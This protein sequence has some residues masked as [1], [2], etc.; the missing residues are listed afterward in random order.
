[1]SCWDLLLG[2][3]LQHVV[4]TEPP[5]AVKTYAYLLTQPLRTVAGHGRRGVIH[6]E[7]LR[8][9][10][11]Q[12]H[13]SG[14][15]YFVGTKKRQIVVPWMPEH[16]ELL[17]VDALRRVQEEAARFGEWLLQCMLDVLVHDRDYGDNVRPN[18]LVTKDVRGRLEL[19]RFY[20][21]AKV[22]FEFNGPQHYTITDYTPTRSQ[23]EEQQRLDRIKAELCQAEGIRLITVQTPELDFKILAEK[24]GDSLP[25]VPLREESPIYRYLTRTARAYLHNLRYPELVSGN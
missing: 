7:T 9:A 5:W 12:L 4:L 24:I 15:V 6:P 3:A 10:V 17:V 16:V 20:R 19:D 11:Q 1:M 18:W 14:W 2:T 22:A 25:L 21:S 8:R 13:A 23:L